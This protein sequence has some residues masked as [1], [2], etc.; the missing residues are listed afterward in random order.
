MLKY[1]GTTLS[2][3]FFFSHLQ[4]LLYLNMCDKNKT[5]RCFHCYSVCGGIF[6]KQVNI[7]SRAQ[8]QEVS[9]FIKL[10]YRCS[11][12]QVF[13]CFHENEL[14]L[15]VKWYN[16]EK[17]Y[18][19]LSEDYLPYTQSKLMFKGISVFWLLVCL[20]LHSVLYWSESDFSK[21]EFSCTA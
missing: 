18:E 6:F 8:E 7:L 10:Q 20:A 1:Q 11:Y 15:Y 14:K 19:A 9:V 3:L 13:L 16:F 4:C 17:W 21:P 2:A 12:Q 5:N